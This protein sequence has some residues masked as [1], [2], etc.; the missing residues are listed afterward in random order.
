MRMESAIFLGACETI[1]RTIRKYSL[2]DYNMRY[3]RSVTVSCIVDLTYLLTY[4]LFGA[5]SLLRS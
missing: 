5:E 2:E 4:L 3:A 1:E